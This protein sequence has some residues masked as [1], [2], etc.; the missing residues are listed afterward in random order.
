MTFWP[1]QPQYYNIRGACLWKISNHFTPKSRCLNKTCLDFVGSKPLVVCS[2]QFSTENYVCQISKVKVR[3]A[4]LQKVCV[5]FVN[6]HRTSVYVMLAQTPHEDWHG[7]LECMAIGSQPV[8]LVIHQREMCLPGYK[9]EVL[10]DYKC[11]AKVY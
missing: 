10:Q 9:S 3:I 6:S 5:M 1:S 8:L 7:S 11:L 4:R 2:S